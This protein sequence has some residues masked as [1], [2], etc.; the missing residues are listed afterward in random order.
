M[1]LLA[2]LCATAE[3]MFFHAT[4]K[5]QEVASTLIIIFFLFSFTLNNCNSMKPTAKKR[6]IFINEMHEIV[7]PY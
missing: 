3:R 5:K 6:R 2:Q 1:I 4:K 7:Y